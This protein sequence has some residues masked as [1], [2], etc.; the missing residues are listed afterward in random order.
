[1]GI[2]IMSVIKQLSAIT[3][4]R[5]A[6]GEV[7]ERP[8]SV[9][10]ELVENSL[11]A[12]ATEVAI[13]IEAGG[14]NLILVQ[15]NGSGM[16][17]DD[18]ELSVERHTT[19]KL[20]D[21]DLLNIKYYGFRGEA[22]ATISSV[23]RLKISSRKAPDENGWVVSLE[24]GKNKT[25]QP[26]PHNIGTKV[27]V[28]DLFYATPARL[29]FLRSE[30][31]EN[32]HIIEVIQKIALV[33]PD[34]NFHLYID[35][36]Q[37]FSYEANKNMSGNNQYG[38]ILSVLGNEFCD[39]SIEVEQ[40]FEGIKLRGYISLPTYSK[41]TFTESIFFINGRI[42][43]DKLVQ[44]AIKI[45]YQDFIPSG[46]YPLVVLMLNL[47]PELIDVNVHPTK[48]EVRF[49]DPNQI[50]NVLIAGLKSAL[51][52]KA[53]RT[54]TT[55]A[56]EA[57]GSFITEQ[58]S[59]NTYQPAKIDRSI[60]ER[61]SSSYAPS[62]MQSSGFRQNS[63]FQESVFKY[64]E[65]EPVAKNFNEE[66][67]QFGHEHKTPELQKFP[68]GAALCQI[69]PTFIISQTDDSIIITDQHA[70]HERLLYEKLKNDSLQKQ[71]DSQRLLIPEI[72]EINEE[73]VLEKIANSATHLANLGIDIEINKN[74]VV[75][76]SIPQILG[77]V[78][79]AQL[80][81]DVISDIKEYDE[82]SSLNN[83]V[84]HRLA[85][86]ACHNS[87]RSGKSLNISEMNELL[88][89]MEQTPHSGQCNHGR[90]TYIELKLKD[91]E[92]LF[93]RE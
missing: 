76:H 31:V 80:I 28:R 45:A 13:R 48:A 67:S 40:N 27:E 74:M 66:I 93:G 5:I 90:P 33:Y 61:T 52:E 55:I 62:H 50:K 29:K 84:K 25:I 36:K 38:A 57:I 24:G 77:L 30:K 85:T 34:K 22:L 32:Q 68:L 73:D 53:N 86:Y 37:V 92:K 8:S 79:V 91:I 82:P 23:S 35:D 10:K 44:I 7:V 39:N 47:S 46:R 49:R 43:R 54:A 18:L 60:F 65:P 71:L 21:D 81:R 51:Q 4:N 9:V 89:Q 56:Q 6:A 87:I 3:I 41:S 14:R 26:V 20:S 64:E 78:N 63:Q 12:G 72:V 17:K 11:D 70:A 1:M 2:M 83:L 69:E 75:V 88:R 42:V 19:S 15:D 59:Q 16:D 58:T